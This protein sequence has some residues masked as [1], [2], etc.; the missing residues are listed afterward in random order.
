MITAGMLA[1][2]ELKIPNLQALSLAQEA[3]GFRRATP[4]DKFRSSYENPVDLHVVSQRR[5]AIQGPIRDS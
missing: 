3:P 5:S 2:R 4:L 1:T